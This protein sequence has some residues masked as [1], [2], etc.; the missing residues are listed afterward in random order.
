[1]FIKKFLVSLF[2]LSCLCCACSDDS[3]GNNNN[4][5]NNNNNELDECKDLHCDQIVG[6]RAHDC[7]IVSGKASCKP[8]CLGKKEGNNDPVCWFH[9]SIDPQTWK[10]VVDTCAKDDNG[11][12]YSTNS[13][14][15]PCTGDCSESTGICELVVVDDDP[16]DEEARRICDGYAG[17]PAHACFAINGEA[18]CKVPCHGDK[19]GRN[20]PYCYRNGS[21][22]VS[23]VDSIQDVCAKDD[24][25][26]LYVDTQVVN[27]CPVGCDNGNCKPV[28]NCENDEECLVDGGNDRICATLR[29]S[30]EKACADACL[31]Q[32]SAEPFV[33]ACQL[34]SSIPDAKPKSIFDYC[35]LDG[36]TPDGAPARYYSVGREVYQECNE[37]CN[38]ETGRCND[39]PSPW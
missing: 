19:E 1:M 35:V 20:E 16:C 12:L 32:E 9:S 38:E 10:S 15:T 22:P 29:N 2:S 7:F 13:N 5:N 33:M 37:G 30:V 39:D 8:S 14:E 23:I 21:L 24:K 27:N 4:N 11:E 6:G 25:G 26:V 18:Q 28:V 17:G 31:R 34:N 36:G 3:G